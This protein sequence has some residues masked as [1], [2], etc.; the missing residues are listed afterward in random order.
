MDLGR[1]TPKQKEVYRDEEFLS[2]LA[3]LVERAKRF[4]WEKLEEKEKNEGIGFDLPN[5]ENRGYIFVE[6]W[7]EEDLWYLRVAA[8]RR[9]SDMFWNHFYPE[10][11]LENIKAYLKDKSNISQIIDSIIELSCSVDEKM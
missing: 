3:D 11:T 4:L 5:T 1:M 9:W 2:E 6:K 10:D 8:S 7:Y